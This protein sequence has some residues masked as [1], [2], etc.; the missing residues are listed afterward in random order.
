MNA[1]K[2]WKWWII[3]GVVV[4]L[5]LWRVCFGGAPSNADDVLDHWVYIPLIAKEFEPVVVVPTSTPTAV[6]IPTLPPWATATPIPTMC[7]LAFYNYT[8]DELYY[9][10]AGTGFGWK[11]ASA[12]TIG[13]YYESFPAGWYT[14]YAESRECG[15][16]SGNELYPAHEW[17][18]GS[19]SAKHDFTCVDGHLIGT[20][21]PYERSTGN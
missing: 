4:L 3:G 17:L 14:W 1:V 9:L 12:E 11:L 18:P 19:L 20:L 8:G 5:V 15:Q 2:K 16:A 10:V 6:P 7:N 21:G 13:Y